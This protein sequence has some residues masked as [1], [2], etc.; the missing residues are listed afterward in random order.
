VDSYDDNDQ[1][2][3]DG[4]RY[5][6][7]NA[8]RSEPIRNASQY[9]QSDRHFPHPDKPYDTNHEQQD[10]DS[11]SR[12]SR[13][14]FGDMPGYVEETVETGVKLG[15]EVIEE[16][17]RQAKWLAKE[18]SPSRNA[19]GTGN[20]FSWAQGADKLAGEGMQES[21]RYSRQMV[22][23]WWQMMMSLTDQM[24]GGIMSQST[25]QQGSGRDPHHQSWH[26]PGSRVDPAHD[27]SATEPGQW[28]NVDSPYSE[29]NIVVRVNSSRPSSVIFDL[30]PGVDPQQLLAQPL[31]A[32]K[33]DSPP[34]ND[35]SFQTQEDGR[36]CLLVT[37]P[38]DADEGIYSGVVVNQKSGIPAGTI[39][40]Q[41][42]RQV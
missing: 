15:Y 34:L 22:D 12:Q 6:N 7:I 23:G 2:D 11:S 9:V 4:V 33:A 25:R 38:N 40:V 32:L 39:T 31:L 16:Y 36:I 5:R 30:R 27:H 29:A 21:L 8:E 10:G 24:W 18:T 3:Q 20:P 13:S 26:A 14:A 17:L 37:V 35:I 42:E 41:L 1:S 28:H 19:N